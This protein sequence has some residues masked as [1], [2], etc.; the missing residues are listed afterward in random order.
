M[1][2]SS[3]ANCASVARFKA[4]WRSSS[5]LWRRPRIRLNAVIT[6]PEASVMKIHSAR[7]PRAAIQYLDQGKMPMAAIAAVPTRHPRIASTIK[8][9][10]IEVHSQADR[11]GRFQDTNAESRTV[12]ESRWRLKK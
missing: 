6:N 11:G 7:L 8:T 10:V 2:D 9:S 3:D 1:R 5:C 4:R 12:P